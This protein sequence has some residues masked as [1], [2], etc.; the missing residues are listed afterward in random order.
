[1]TG[2]LTEQR[3]QAVERIEELMALQDRYQHPGPHR[4]VTAIARVGGEYRSIFGECRITA[5]WK[6]RKSGRENPAAKSNDEELST[7][8]TTA[9]QGRLIPL[10]EYQT[11]RQIQRN[12]YLRKR[13]RLNP[14]P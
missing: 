10:D 7:E 1:M 4:R 11:W 13:R 2:S 12:T 5:A 6:I 8:G 14:S 9:M 3:R